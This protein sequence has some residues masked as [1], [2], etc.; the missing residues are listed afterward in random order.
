MKVT[1][2]TSSERIKTTM[3]MAAGQARLLSI[4]S[5][6][7]DNE[8]RAQIINNNKMRLATQSSQVSEAYVTALNEAQM[9]FTNYDK[10]NNTSYQRLTYNALT[11]YNPYNNQYIVTNAS[12]NVLLLEADAVNYKNANGDVKKFLQSY[13]LEYTTTYFDNLVSHVENGGIPFKTGAIDAEGKEILGYIYAPN[14][15]G[16][17][18]DSKDVVKYIQDL[19]EGNLD[20]TYGNDNKKLHPGYMNTLS[21]EDYYNYNKLLSDYTVKKDAYLGTIA[22][23]MSEKL[24]AMQFGG[25]N[26]SALLASIDSVNDNDMNTMTGIMNSVGEIIKTAGNYKLSES[27]AYFTNLSDLLNNNKGNTITTT[28]TPSNV[29][30]DKVELTKDSL[31]SLIFK[32]NDITITFPILGNA[33]ATFEKDDGSTQTITGVKQT[34]GSFKFISQDENGEN[35]EDIYKVPE[36]YFNIGFNV[37][38]NWE[39]EQTSQNNLEN[40]KN[41]TKGVIKSLRSSIYSVWDPNNSDFKPTNSSDFGYN[42]YGAYKSAAKALAEQIFGS[43]NSIGEENYAD[44][45]N[46]DWVQEKLK[47]DYTTKD[48]NGNIIE[49]VKRDSSGNIISTKAADFQ[50]IY[51]AYLLDCI[52]DT[53]G[54]PKYAWVSNGAPKNPRNE[55]TDS[56]YNENGDAKAQWY[57][58]LFERIQKGGYKVLQDGLASSPEWMQFAFESGIITME[59]VDANKNWKPLIYSNCSD[60]TEQTNDAAIAKAEAEYKAAMN[61]IENKDKRYDLELK[62]IDTE[63]NSLQVEYDSIKAA[64]DKNIERTF[65]LYS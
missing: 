11:S 19:Y 53:Y 9:M 52:M 32:N 65:K 54:E 23:L 15:N 24:E 10:D 64:I 41:V 8:L 20:E 18:I 2:L 39:I 62:N 33:T 37:P 38:D 35:Q 12:G 36:E 59:Q 1:K 61:K 57:Q 46:I 14:K 49:Y 34:D 3:G 17:N 30:G 25:K 31:G 27:S 4:T 55:L 58:N 60:I 43:S 7:S 22:Q 26:L 56:S 47:D 50:K 44:L 29:D 28:H 63:H 6:M 48:E 21:S 13:G 45:D 51:D 16:N 40:M 5:R 42:E